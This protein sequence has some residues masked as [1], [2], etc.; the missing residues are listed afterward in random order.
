MQH[1]FKVS[2]VSHWNAPWESELAF[3]FLFLCAKMFPSKTQWCEDEVKISRQMTVTSILYFFL[4][5]LWFYNHVEF[6]NCFNCWLTS[7]LTASCQTLLITSLIV[8]LAEGCRVLESQRLNNTCILNVSRGLP[9]WRWKTA[10]FPLVPQSRHFLT[11]LHLDH[12]ETHLVILPSHH[13]CISES[14]RLKEAMFSGWIVNECHWW[15]VDVLML[16]SLL[17]LCVRMCVCGC[18]P[19]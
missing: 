11:H 15:E 17:Q 7:K 12:L 5:F 2:D 18:V 6:F 9:S 14:S 1:N 8:D 19:N 16:R 13:L 3:P 4:E 10:A